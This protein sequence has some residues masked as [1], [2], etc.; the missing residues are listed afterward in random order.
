LY[1]PVAQRQLPA[2]APGCPPF[3][4]KDTVLGDR[5]GGQPPDETTVWPGAYEM[6]D[7]ESR[8]PYTVVWWDPLL[9]EGKADDGRG[10][11]REELISKEAAPADVAADRARYDQWRASRE[12]VQRAGARPSV[13]MLTATEW[14]ADPVGRNFSSAAGAV[15]IEDASSPTPR[16]SGRRFGVLV[17]ALLAVVPLDAGAKEVRDLAEV[18]ARILGATDEER[19]AAAATVDRVMRHPILVA[20]HQA[21]GAGRACRREAPVSLVVDG[22][23]IDGQADLAYEDTD[24]WVVVDFKTDVE[25]SGAE[26]AY[27]RQVALYVE[28]IAKATGKPARGLLL[29]I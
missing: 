23:L 14:A 4:G 21:A 1:P 25:L 22:V 20:A 16:P 9:L 11:R 8:E 2:A 6:T 10:L 7:P 3:K 29:K 28:A 13:T 12:A 19:A 15:S 26:D 24:G 17:H 18:Q 5:P 27:R